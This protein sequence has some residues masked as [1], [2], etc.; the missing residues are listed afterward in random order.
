MV[1]II[2]SFM[3]SHTLATAIMTVTAIAGINRVNCR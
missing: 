3:A 2:G 1:P